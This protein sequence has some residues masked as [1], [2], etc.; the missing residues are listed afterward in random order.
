M[1]DAR[2]SNHEIT[3]ADDMS[4]AEPASSLLDHV[5][6]SHVS[7]SPLPL[8]ARLP[9]LG[10]RTTA[11]VILAQTAVPSPPRIAPPSTSPS[12]DWRDVAIRYLSVA[13]LLVGVLAMAVQWRYHHASAE[14][15]RQQTS[16]PDRPTSTRE[17]QP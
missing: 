9:D 4:S 7:H 13:V 5:S 17:G 3:P 1:N 16:V 10:S 12:G 2:T 14:T 15:A 6:H 11:A 8:I